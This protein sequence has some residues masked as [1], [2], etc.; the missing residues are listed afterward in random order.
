MSIISNL[1]TKT[2]SQARDTTMILFSRSEK[3]SEEPATD[4]IWLRSLLM[5]L[6][7]ACGT[8]P[9]TSLAD[10]QRA[11]ALT[12]NP[13]HHR[14]RK[15]IDVKYHWIREAVKARQIQLEYIPTTDMAADG[16]TKPL[17][18][19]K[20]QRFSDMLGMLH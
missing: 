2:T 3:D 19:V 20:F 4:A 8:T 12:K 9:V 14:R 13:K 10:N 16:M 11:I 17:G 15:H 6:H 1:T 18:R 7:A 5:E